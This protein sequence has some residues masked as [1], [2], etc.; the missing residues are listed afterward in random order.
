MWQWLA[1]MILII[2]MQMGLSRTSY[3]AF[4]G[5]LKAVF[6]WLMSTKDQILMQ[7]RTYQAVM[8]AG[9]MGICLGSNYEV[10]IIRV[11]RP[12]AAVRGEH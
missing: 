11:Q 2:M 7:V 5:A 1:V 10:Q 4:W 6:C 8:I 9:R 12:S 3:I